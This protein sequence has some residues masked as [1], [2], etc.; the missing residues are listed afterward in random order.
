MND[1]IIFAARAVPG[2]HMIITDARTND[3]ILIKMADVVS[4]IMKS[5]LI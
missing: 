3:V 2:T 5:R 4:F 1:L